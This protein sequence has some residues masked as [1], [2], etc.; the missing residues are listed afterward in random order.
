MNGIAGGNTT[1]GRVD[2]TGLYQAPATLPSPD[3]TSIEATSAADGTASGRASVTVQNPVPGLTSVLP[4]SIP[5]GNFTLSVSGTNF[6]S[7]A[8]VVWGTKFLTTTFVS[9]TELRATGSESTAGTIKVTVVN[10]D[11]GSS[12]SGAFNVLVA[13]AALPNVISAPVAARFLEQAT[14]GPNP[15]LIALV[16]QQGIENHL[17]EELAYGASTYAAPAPGDGMDVV[18]A[19]FF[20]DARSKTNQLRQRVAFALS[21]IMVASA[22]KVNNPSAFVLWQNM[23]QKD[24]FANFLTLLTDVTLSPTMGNYLDMVNNDKPDPVAGTSPNEN[25]GREVL[26]LFSIGLNE[27]NQDGTFQLDGSGNPIPTYTQDTVEGFAHAFTG[28]TYP[29]KPGATGHFRN[30]EYYGG[31]MIAFG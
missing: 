4:T 21:Q 1:V 2:A 26:Q 13:A 27:L 15:Y 19:R 25:Y 29:T 7:G 12:S 5:P 8:V 10:P 20:L 3:P 28:W 14:W 22:I 6:T 31:P 16:Q 17:N 11:P 9:A 30:P 18:Q 24:A 23:F